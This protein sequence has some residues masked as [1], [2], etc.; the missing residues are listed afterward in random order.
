VPRTPPAIPWSVGSA[1]PAPD[2]RS[3]DT[4]GEQSWDDAGRPP[5]LSVRGLGDSD[6]RV[7]DQIAAESHG[8]P[9]RPARTAAHLKCH[10]PGRR[11]RFPQRPAGRQPDRAEL[12]L[13][14][15]AA[16]RRYATARPHG[17][18]RAYRRPC[19]VSSCGRKARDRPC[20]GRPSAGQ[21]P[22]RAR[23]AG[24]VR[25]PARPVRRLPIGCCQRPA[26]RAPCAGRSHPGRDRSGPAGL[27]PRPG[28]LLVRTRT[29]PPNSSARPPGRRHAAAFLQRSAQLTV[30]PTRRAER[31]PARP[32]ADRPP[33]HHPRRRHRRDR[34][35]RARG[36]QA[37]GNRAG[38][39]L[40]DHHHRGR[41]PHPRRPKPGPDRRPVA[42]SHRSGPR[43]PRRLAY[44][45]CRPGQQKPRG[46]GCT[47][48]AAHLT[49]PTRL[50]SQIAELI[51]AGRG[52]ASPES[53]SVSSPYGSPK[54]G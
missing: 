27:A 47:L 15:P 25:A 2:V 11:V 52:S 46:G 53:A 40:P 37:P 44:P 45:S 26:P 24:R 42:A 13:A 21:R 32:G 19:L 33:G 30:E 51:V 39:R 20:G 18:R 16:P 54:S 22:A 43:R 34:H 7:C 31:S 50:K 36:R 8:D 41:T 38:Q 35:R 14:P 12:C 17:G 3:A 4:G 6:G 28:P 10:R 23:R 5:E 49:R 48:L 1:G 29:S 9:A